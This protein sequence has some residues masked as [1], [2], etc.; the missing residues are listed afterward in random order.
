VTGEGKA[1]PADQKR[2]AARF[3]VGRKISHRRAVVLV[4]ISRSS[5][6]YKGHGRP[7]DP[8]LLGQLKSLAARHPRFGY[9]R[10]WSLLR[11]QGRVVNVKRVR[12]LC[13]KHGL[14]LRRRARR[15]YKGSGASVPCRAEH[16]N[17][18]WTCD[19]VHDQCENG[20]KLKLL[21]VVDEFTRECHRIEVATRISSRGVIRVLGELFALHGVPRFIRSDNGPEFIGRELK[22]W[23]KEQGSATHYI[24]PGS[25]W[26]NGYGESFNGKLRDEC[27]NMETFHHPDHARAVVELWRR[28]YNTQRPHSSLGYRTPAEFRE[29]LAKDG[30]CAA[31][32]CVCS[33]PEDTGAV[34]ALSSGGGGT[35]QGA[36]VR[37][38]GVPA[39]ASGS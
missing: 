19:F 2:Q 31:G 8:E 18:V 35:N 20:R 17:H 29:S 34:Q 9:R 24:E 38:R 33:P 1:S 39:R 27:L 25:P 37:T 23:L 15:K 21:S 5:L 12:R 4:G 32:V 22:H 6:S 11:R 10:L 3:L 14:S 7:D 28:Q 26:Q 36:A 30:G 13:V 16:V